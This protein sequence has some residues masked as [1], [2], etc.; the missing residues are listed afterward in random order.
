MKKLLL[1]IILCLFLSE[2][3]LV[4]NPKIGFFSYFLLITGILIVLSIKNNEINYL[5]NILIILII[6]PL[7][8]IAGFFIE[9]EF[10]YKILVLYLIMFFLII[11]YLIKFKINPG[12]NFNKFY[13]LPLIILIGLIFGIIG[14]KLINLN[15]GLRFLSIILLIVFSEEFLFRGLI[16][17]IILKKQGEFIGILSSSFLYGIFHLCFGFYIGLLFLI[18]GFI[19]SYIYYISKNIFLGMIVSLIINLLIFV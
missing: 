19:I 15:L 3:I 5:E 14:N 4:I 11:F 18:L 12:Y 7:I 6:L 8:R 17:N 2:I 13:L 1:L 9:L 10:F 16:Q